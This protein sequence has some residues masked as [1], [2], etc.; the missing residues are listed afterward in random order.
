MGYMTGEYLIAIIHVY[1]PIY[2]ATAQA[3]QVHC[4][5]VLGCNMRL[6]YSREKRRDTM[7]HTTSSDTYTP[8]TVSHTHHGLKQAEHTRCML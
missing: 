7:V 1:L 4:P 6:V 2:V 5:Q 3:N 8:H